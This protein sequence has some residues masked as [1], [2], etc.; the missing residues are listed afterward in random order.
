M[1]SLQRLLAVLGTAAL[2]L[3]LLSSPAQAA[4][5]RGVHASSNSTVVSRNDGGP[6][7]GWLVGARHTNAAEYLLG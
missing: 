3:P 6:H 4:P 7:T 5:Q 2:A 1:T